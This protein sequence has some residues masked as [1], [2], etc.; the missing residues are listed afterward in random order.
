MIYIILILVVW[1]IIASF[2]LPSPPLLHKF[3]GGEKTRKGFVEEQTF[4]REQTSAHL[5][6]TNL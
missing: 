5:T 6:S 1:S 4:N 2:E 3:P